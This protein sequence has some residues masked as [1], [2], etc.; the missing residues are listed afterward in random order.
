MWITGTRP[1]VASYLKRQRVLQTILASSG[2]VE[3][4]LFIDLEIYKITYISKAYLEIYMSPPT[5]YP[6][7]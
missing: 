7:Q 3:W 5:C 2:L 6:R 1:I 4:V